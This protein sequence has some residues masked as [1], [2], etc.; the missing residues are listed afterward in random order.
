MGDAIDGAPRCRRC[1]RRLTDQQ[2]VLRGYGRQCWRIVHT[3]PFLIPE[4]EQEILAQK[5]EKKQNRFVS[6]VKRIFESFV[7]N[8][9]HVRVG[10]E[11]M[12]ITEYN[13]RYLKGKT[14][15][16]YQD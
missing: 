1:K 14:D 8:D 15:A 3:Q 5:I 11:W 16:K 10:R 2:S 6:W 12:A 4:V 9:A 13:R 7:A